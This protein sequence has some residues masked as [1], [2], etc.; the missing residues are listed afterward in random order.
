MMQKAFINGCI[1]TGEKTLTEHTLYTDNDKISHI[2]RAPLSTDFTGDVIDLNGQILAPGLIDIQVNG[3]GGTLFNDQPTVSGLTDIVSAHYQYGTVAM[4]PTL[5]SDSE[6]KIA[7]AI[8]AVNNAIAEAVPGIIGLHLEGPFLN[9]DYK[10]VHNPD[11]FH[12]VQHSHIPL[13]TSI[14]NGAMLITLAPEKAESGVIKALNEQGVVVFAGHTGATYD[15]TIDAL[16]EGLAGFTHLFNAMTPLHKREP[17]VVGA[18]LEDSQ[19]YCGIIV[20]RYHVHPTALKIAIK[21]KA[22]GK[23]ILVTD[24]MPTVGARDKRFVLNNETIKAENG[25]CATAD[26]TLA[27]SDLDMISAVKNS[28]DSLGVTWQE[29]IRMGS[30]YPAQCLNI[31]HQLGF[32]KPG[33]KASMIQ[34]DHNIDLQ[35][36][37]IE[38]QSVFAKTG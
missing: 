22:S 13:L 32:L 21:A 36:V 19:S 17:G 35:Q 34:I 14:H 31:D 27:G 6:K 4:L 1:F 28:V 25:R 33:F 16:A 5:I 37:W 3:G 38:G 26:N 18:A 24:A 8:E 9:P 10:G 15:E 11:Y 2:I 23:M 7:L 20:D 30:T 29:A 12:P